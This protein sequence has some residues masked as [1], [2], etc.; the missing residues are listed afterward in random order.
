[1]S[2]LSRTGYARNPSYAGGSSAA[3][4]PTRVMGSHTELLDHASV[5]RTV[6]QCGGLSPEDWQRDPPLTPGRIST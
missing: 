3:A 1:M 5:R 2:S 6:Y 4:S